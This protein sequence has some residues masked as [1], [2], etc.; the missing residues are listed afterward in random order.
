MLSY[1][2]QSK[3]H[4]FSR[5]NTSAHLTLFP[6]E[7]FTA[8][9]KNTGVTLQSLIT[10][11]CRQHADNIA[12]ICNNE[13]LTYDELD[14]RANQ[15]AQYFASRAIAPGSRI[16]IVLERSINTYVTLLAIIKAGAVFVP[17]D[18][19]FPAERISY[20]AQDASLAALVT[21]SDIAS[22]L[23]DIAC[24]FIS[25]DEY[26]DDIC[27][28]SCFPPAG[29][30]LQSSNNNQLCYI[31]YTSGSTGTP[32]GVAIEHPS[33]CNFIQVAAKVYDIQPNDR[34]YQ[35]M[36][37]AFD[38]SIEEI[39]PGLLKGATLV[40]GPVDEQR[41]GTD[42]ADF[43]IKNNITAFCCVPTLL[44]T[45]D[46]DI[47][48]LR[49]LIV[50]GEACPQNLVERWAIPG[51]RMLNTYGPTET[52]VTAT[53]G[54]LFPGKAVTIGKPMPTYTV[55]IL[56]HN[57]K[58]VSPG[59]T[60]EICIAGIGLAAGYINHKEKTRLAFIP[61][62]LNTPNNPSGRIYRT[63]DLGRYCEN[64][65]IEYLGRIDS[66]VK[67]RGYRIELTEIESVILET[68]E[69]QKV[70]V[71]PYRIN[72]LCEELVA[73]CEVKKDVEK[74]DCESIR[75][76][77]SNRLPAYMIPAYI[78]QIESI[79][80]LANGKI[81]RNNLPDP[82]SCQKI[83]SQTPYIA[84]AGHNEHFI[85]KQLC[86]LLNLQEVSVKDNFFNDLG[87]HSLIMAQL[88][89]ILRKQETM[90]T[91]SLRDVYHYPTIRQLSRRITTLQHHTKTNATDKKSA[92]PTY[93]NQ[94]V[95]CCGFFQ[96]LAILLI[97]AIYALPGIGTLQWLN[98]RIIWHS[99]N[100]PLIALAGSIG[101]LVSFI[102]TLAFPVIYS[103]LLFN[104]ISHGKH[105]LWGQVFFRFW[106]YDK[107]LS[108]AP[109]TL[110]S[111]TPLLASYYR[112]FGAKIGKNVTL[113]SPLL[114]VPQMITIGD[115]CAI[116]TGSHIFGYSIKSNSLHFAPV[117]LEKQC[118]VG[119]NSV[120]MPGVTMLQ[121]SSLG[122]QSVL[123]KNN[124]VE[125]K[126]HWA[127]SP[128]CPVS[129]TNKQTEYD[130]VQNSKSSLHWLYFMPPILLFPLI[131]YAAAFPALMAGAYLNLSR[132]AFIALSPLAAL[133]FIVFLHLLIIG[134]KKCIQPTIQ[135]G[136]Y[137]LS[138]HQYLRKYCV[139]RLM[140]LSLGLTNSLYATLYLAPFL[141]KMGATIGNMAEI[142][143]ISH[144]TPD[145][146]HIDDESFVADIAHLGP[147]RIANGNFTVA[148]VYIGK[149]SFVG[150]AAFVPGGTRINEN[151]LI[152]VL[153]IPAEQ[154]VPSATTWL[155][156]PPLL[157][158]EREPSATFPERLTFKPTTSLY[159][160]RLCYEFFRVTGPT[161]MIL[162]GA[163]L[164]IVFSLYCLKTVSVTTTALLLAPAAAVIS[165]ILILC[166][167][168][169]KTILIGR[170]RPQ[171]QPMWSTF[172][173]RSE[174]VT[175]LYENVAVPL[176]LSGLAGTPLMAPFLR[177]FGV[178]IGSRCCIE[179]T[180]IT[181]FDLVQIG[182]D[183][184]IS[185]FCSLQTHLFEDRVM[186]MAKLTIG[187]CCSIGPRAV[188]LYNATLEDD[189]ILEGMSLVMKGET[190]TDTG[191]WHGSPA[192][193]HHRA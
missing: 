144:I 64:G 92:I 171:V 29:K 133:S 94:Q 75:R 95:W 22:T 67:I 136:T 85:A 2:D 151:S 113:C 148:P 66:Q 1:V 123:E 172:V 82:V 34:I 101:L 33:I 143:T 9:C 16:G 26:T 193:I 87:A 7:K 88:V 71:A 62:T 23:T 55:Y 128:A 186:K 160:R 61:D 124:I 185:K 65:E 147:A 48:S 90:A 39:W 189:V 142:S 47:P 137:P 173:W 70:A 36:T 13:Q 114:H 174:L 73:Y 49:T 117:V 77:L 187:N 178:R 138:S 69:I 24:P 59:T 158:P 177:L 53:W 131:P 27:K 168:A 163:L 112:L 154:E 89:S 109:L 159:L 132:P 4:V 18:K 167:A 102:F 21:T 100:Y 86:T 19:S 51:R 157:L 38:F 139:D 103:K 40:A 119:S 56:D 107:L 31:I 156:S 192:T 99:P 41:L 15:L 81:D 104:N 181:E 37:I 17:M 188:I 129:T 91:L 68:E 11:S 8:P 122:N 98:E 96:V 162:L 63:G 153:S 190:L 111:G 135:P 6:T 149:R 43:L 10:A 105:P 130:P 35:G 58:P 54:E 180:Y 121:S 84:P 46:K 108:M 182:D 166:I 120:L 191:H 118:L 32:K 170:Y 106:I 145:L 20:I 52:T 60:G 14:C 152:G 134:L 146:L 140:D 169:V 97:T 126:E 116:N 164:L 12:V 78:E 28:Q 93:T 30:S 74:L 176:L 179:T 150:N 25:L 79:P 44:A 125:K 141:K 76:K 127:G 57:S 115:D 165:C 72:E 175:A 5:D 161:S 3:Y 42:L 45:I 184:A 50:G 80:L 183:C 155:G 110:L 83:S